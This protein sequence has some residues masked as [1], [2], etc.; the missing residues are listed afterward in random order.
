M[1]QGLRR[2]LAKRILLGRALASRDAAHELLPKILALPVFASDALSSVAYATEE[3]LHVLIG[4]LGASPATSAC[5]SRSRS[6][7]RR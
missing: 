5:R 4:A 3:I 2:P 6:R 7:C 1:S